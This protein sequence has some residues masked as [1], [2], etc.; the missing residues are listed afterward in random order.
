MYLLFG[1]L[2]IRSLLRGV[3]GSVSVFL[4]GVLFATGAVLVGDEGSAI[5]TDS[6]AVT[7]ST[8]TASIM[9][10]VFMG[11]AILAEWR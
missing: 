10:S 4:E 5:A 8:N 9:G 6:I 11:E 2:W 7:A 3:S 1:V